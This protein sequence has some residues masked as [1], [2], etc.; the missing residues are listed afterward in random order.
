MESQVMMVEVEVGLN[1]SN[2]VIS[3]TSANR[4]A[5]GASAFDFQGLSSALSGTGFALGTGGAGSDDGSTPPNAKN[6]SP[7]TGVGSGGGGAGWYGGN[8]GN[9]SLGGGGGGAAGLSA[10]QTGGNGGDGVL[11]LQFNNTTNVL[12]TSGT[13]YTIP[14]QT[15]FIKAWLIGAGGGGAGSPSSDGTSGGGGAA[16]G[17]AY[18]AWT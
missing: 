14:A 16:G 15:N 4:G 2:A 18:Y 9:G 8:G 6:G 17:I 5:N 12:V 7:G 13:S 10:T 3:P 1:G 11:L